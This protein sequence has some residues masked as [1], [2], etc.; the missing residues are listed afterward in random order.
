MVSVD[1]VIIQDGINCFE[2]QKTG[3]CIHLKYL[4]LRF[5][6]HF[7][8]EIRDLLSNLAMAKFDIS[9]AHYLE[10]NAGSEFKFSSH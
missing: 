7:S 6:I 3:F 5:T 1:H 10:K 2:A 8:G 4:M 9:K